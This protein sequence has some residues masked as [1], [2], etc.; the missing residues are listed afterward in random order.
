MTIVE[1][2]KTVDLEKIAIASQI[3]AVS[4]LMYLYMSDKPRSSRSHTRRSGKK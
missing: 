1:L 4:F 2:S 3:I